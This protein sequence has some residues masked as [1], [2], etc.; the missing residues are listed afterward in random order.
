LTNNHYWFDIDNPADSY[1]GKYNM[2]FEL[3]EKGEVEL[4]NFYG[5]ITNFKLFDV[6]NDNVS[7][8]LQ[9][10]PTHSHLIVNDTARKIVALGG[11]ATN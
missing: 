2:E 4:N 10:Y 8:I 9:M 1:V 3:A 7:E 11:V 5:S 6:Y